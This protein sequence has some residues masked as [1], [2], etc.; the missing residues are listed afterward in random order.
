MVTIWEEAE[1]RSCIVVGSME[2]EGAREVQDFLWAGRR[3]PGLYWDSSLFERVL[4]D[5]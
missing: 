3:T 4:E 1:T 2:L 5:P